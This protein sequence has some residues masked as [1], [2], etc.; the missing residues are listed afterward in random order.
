MVM[1]YGTLPLTERLNADWR[2]T[3]ESAARG[4]E[5]GV[6][7]TAA[8]AVAHSPPPPYRAQIEISVM[9]ER[10]AL[11]GPCGGGGGGLS[12]VLSHQQSIEGGLN[13]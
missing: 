8:A 4:E 7:A 2:A 12:R 3:E 13:I 6:A 11:G 10:I 5:R 9:F 1:C